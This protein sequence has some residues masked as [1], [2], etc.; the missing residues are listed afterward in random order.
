LKLTLSTKVRCL[1]LA[2]LWLGLWA[3]LA[4]AQGGAV[5]ADTVVPAAAPLLPGPSVGSYLVKM[6]AALAF[7]IILIYLAVYAYKRFLAPQEM[8]AGGTRA[9]RL[10]GQVYLGPRK[11]LCLVEFPDRIVVLGMSQQGITP[12]TELKDPQVMTV[13]RDEYANVGLHQ[14][15]AQYLKKFMP[16]KTEKN[17]PGT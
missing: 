14:Q 7:V 12:V 5:P 10:L 17:T 2:G 15:F 13:I 8:R 1:A 3:G 9:V 16:D 11:S 6:A 4:A